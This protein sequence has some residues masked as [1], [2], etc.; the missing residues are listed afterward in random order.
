MSSLKP[1]PVPG[2]TLRPDV[3]GIRERAK[4]G[5]LPVWGETGDPN[6]AQTSD[7]TALFTYV[8][9]LEAQAVRWEAMYE[10]M[11]AE[12]D[13]YWK[14]VER[15]EAQLQ[16]AGNALEGFVVNFEKTLAA[17]E[18]LS[19]PLAPTLVPKFVVEGRAALKTLGRE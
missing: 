7:L 1:T 19:G 17:L 10:G 3:E 13:G 8:A 16:T 4:H 14:D 2:E 6:V 12:R 5:W 18:T 15:L 11:M 9:H